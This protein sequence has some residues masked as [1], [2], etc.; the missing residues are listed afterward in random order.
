MTN[1]YYKKNKS[2]KKSFEKKH[3]KDIEIFLKKKKTEDEYR[4]HFFRMQKIKTS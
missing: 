1:N 3:V 4:K 2:F